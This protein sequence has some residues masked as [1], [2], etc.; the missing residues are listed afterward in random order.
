MHKGIGAGW[1]GK[2]SKRCNGKASGGN[3]MRELAVWNVW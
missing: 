3:G 1:N 2:A